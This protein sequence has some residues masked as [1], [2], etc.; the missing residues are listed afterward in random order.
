MEKN[1][2]RLRNQYKESN[3][4]MIKY[5]TFPNI[6][7]LILFL[8]FTLLYIEKH[9]IIGLFKLNLHFAPVNVLVFGKIGSSLFAFISILLSVATIF[10]LKSKSKRIDIYFVFSLF[11]ICSILLSAMSYGIRPQI[12]FLLS[13]FSLLITSYVLIQYRFFLEIDLLSYLSNV[14]FVVSVIS[15]VFTLP[16]LMQ[17]SELLKYSYVNEWGNQRLRGATSDYE[18]TAEILILGFIS[19][20][21]LS[22][23]IFSFQF[24]KFVLISIVLVL[25]GTRAAFLA[26]LGALICWISLKKEKIF[27]KR[28]VL[29]SLT[30][31]L[32]LYFFG[33]TLIDRFILQQSSTLESKLNREKVWNLYD[34]LNLKNDILGR[35]P[36]YPFEK[37]GFFPHSLFKSLLYIGGWITV[38]FFALA[39]AQIIVKNLRIISDVDSQ[40]GRSNLVLLF[41]FLTDQTKVEFTRS[42]GYIFF[43]G[44]FLAVASTAKESGRIQQNGKGT[45]NG[46]VF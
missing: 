46:I 13:W 2:K 9:S 25:T 40:V 20:S 27:D 24:L 38:V 44:I 39:V 43:I 4:I 41:V 14:A 32:S 37:Y 10:S 17:T 12:W 19:A 22:K 3:R 26:P 31:L 21:V 15:L 1:R 16:N 18:L 28:I 35:G 33:S 23:K 6:S 29:L 7:L 36:Y 5:L 8:G 34:K 30:T 11:M 42:G 45:D